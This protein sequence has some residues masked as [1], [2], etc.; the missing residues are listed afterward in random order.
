MTDYQR[1]MDDG[2]IVAP[3]PKIP[4]PSHVSEAIRT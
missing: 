1:G 4:V 2:D 3:A